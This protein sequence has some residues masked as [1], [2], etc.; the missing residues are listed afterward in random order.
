MS[1]FAE[2][3]AAGIETA[4]EAILNALPN[5]DK[6]AQLEAE[7]EGLQATVTRLITE[8][9]AATKLL[10]NAQQELYAIKGAQ[11]TASEIRRENNAKLAERIDELEKGV[12]ELARERD[13][14]NTKN[15]TLAYQLDQA[16]E[17]RDK[18]KESRHKDDAD[19]L[20]DRLADARKE[21]TEAQKMIKNLQGVRDTWQAR[22]EAKDNEIKTQ[23]RINRELHEK[24]ESFRGVP[25]AHEIE[26][27]L[28]EFGRSLDAMNRL[29]CQARDGDW[30]TP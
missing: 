13:Q 30:S 2:D 3:I 10:T 9:T 7:V 14:L 29:H 22:C 25:R 17:E 1:K 24:I 5:R 15:I 4:V 16:L 26:N 19:R 11:E 6:V 20:R 27:W 8:K 23:V 21:L 28:H 12:R 18:L